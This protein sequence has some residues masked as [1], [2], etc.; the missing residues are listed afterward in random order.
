MWCRLIAHRRC[1]TLISQQKLNAKTSFPKSFSTSLI[2][3]DITATSAPNLFILFLYVLQEQKKRNNSQLKEKDRIAST[4]WSSRENTEEKRKI[5]IIK[6]AEKLWGSCMCMA[7]MRWPML[8]ERR[9]K[10]R[11]E[12]ETRR[13]VK[14]ENKCQLKK[15]E[16]K[17]IKIIDCL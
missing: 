11:R 17:Y 5:V 12:M 9:K 15:K 3:H 14:E 7:F 13:N 2:N 10:S 8:P 16:E 4:S 6:V 1:I